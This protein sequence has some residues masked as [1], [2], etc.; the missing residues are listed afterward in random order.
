MYILQLLGSVPVDRAGP[1]LITNLTV[2]VHDHD[3]N[4][5]AAQVMVPKT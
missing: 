4:C 5:E 1:F 2:P 3:S